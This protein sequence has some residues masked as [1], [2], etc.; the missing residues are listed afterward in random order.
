MTSGHLAL[1]WARFRHPVTVTFCAGLS[2]IAVVSGPF[3]TLQTFSFPE[4]LVYW[5]SI[6]YVSAFLGYIARCLA[7]R[8]RPDRR[9]PGYDL[10]AIGLN[11]L[12]ITPFVF[13][14]TVLFQPEAASVG[15]F[16]KIGS[17]V[18]LVSLVVFL[19][20]RILPGFEPEPLFADAVPDSPRSAL[21]EQE[22]PALAEDA[23]PRPRLYRRLPEG[24][25]GDILH[26]AA[27]GHFVTVSLTTGSHRLRLRFADAVDEMDAIAGLCAHRSHWV[28]ISAVAGH[29]RVGGKQ[30]LVLTTGVEVPVSRTYRPGLEARGLLPTA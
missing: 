23:P 29:K 17:Y 2:V 7:Q 27:D 30:F 18:G 10:V 4:R 19:F 11:V 13:G 24:E 1:V 25:V 14:M 16:A 5:T 6:I 15:G 8:Q 3:G 26:L 20:R 22:G 21:P 12:L 9:L 28:A